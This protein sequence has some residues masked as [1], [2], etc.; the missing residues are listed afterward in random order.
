MSTEAEVEEALKLLTR[1]LK[2]RLKQLDLM[3]QLVTSILVNKLGAQEV[4][5]EVPWNEPCH[6]DFCGG[7]IY[8]AVFG[9]KV[10]I[11]YLKLG[12]KKFHISGEH[13]V[14]HALD[15]RSSD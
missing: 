7:T 14:A 9:R 5:E 12:N 6:C 1:V 8:G 3:G 13:C 11:T 4:T 2:Y 10:R 15:S